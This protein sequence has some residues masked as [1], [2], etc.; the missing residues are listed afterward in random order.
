VVTATLNQLDSWFNEPTQGGD[1]PKLLAKL[2]ILE[3]CGW[4]EGEFD[5]L[6]MVV[7]SGRLNDP[8]WVKSNV[9]SGTFGFKYT[10]HWRRMLVG[11]VGE[12]YARRIEE[13]MEVSYPRGVGS[14]KR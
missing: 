9:I 14:T 10:E 3:L 7:E 4:L 1:R 12:I 13:A 6:A 11:L 5:R 8:E 2:A